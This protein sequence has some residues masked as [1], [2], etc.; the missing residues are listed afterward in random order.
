[1]LVFD[2]LGCNWSWKDC[3]AA[4]LPACVLA[5]CSPHCPTTPVNLAQPPTPFSPPTL[6]SCL[7]QYVEVHPVIGP[8]CKLKKLDGSLNKLALL[9]GSTRDAVVRQCF[10]EMVRNWI[11]PD[12]LRY[13]LLNDQTAKQLRGMFTEMTKAK[14]A[15]H[16]E[17]EKIEE[18]RERT[19]R[20][21]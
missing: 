1:M 8:C 17:Y 19:R 7:P 21:A 16:G 4:C 10:N 14:H 20:A 11:A 6:P 3:V 13:P 5:A 15:Q 12:P 9:A 2:A 18:A